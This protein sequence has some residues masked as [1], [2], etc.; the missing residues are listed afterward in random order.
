VYKKHKVLP[1]SPSEMFKEVSEDIQ[2]CEL[3]FDFALASIMFSTT[4]NEET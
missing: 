1:R 2:N 3:K 4:E